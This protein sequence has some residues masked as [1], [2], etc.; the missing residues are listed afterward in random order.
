M[1]EKGKESCCKQR[2]MENIQKRKNQLD[3]IVFTAANKRN[4]AVSNPDNDRY[5]W[6]TGFHFGEWLVPGHIQEGFEITKETSWYVAPMFGYESVRLMGEISG[7]LNKE[8]RH[9]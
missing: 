7:I 8:E 3:N 9:S 6:N 5:L 1:C 2:R 4:E